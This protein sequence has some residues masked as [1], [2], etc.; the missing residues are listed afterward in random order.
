[1][2]KSVSIE[3]FIMLTI[4]LLLG[5][6]G[7]FGTFEVAVGP[8]VA[9][10][11]V[12]MLAGYAIF[13]PLLLVS[14]W[15]GE[16]LR[17]PQLVAGGL[18]LVIGAMPQTYLVAL[19]FVGFD[20]ARALKW[21][22]LPSLYIQVWVIGFLVNAVFVF[23]LGRRQEHAANANVEEALTGKESEV[24]AQERPAGL[25]TNLG[26]DLGRVNAL[27]GEDHYVR[28]FAAGGEHLILMRLRDAIAAVND[29]E[30]VQVHR[31]WWVARPAVASVRRVGRTAELTLIDGT[32]VPVARDMMPRLR[33]L[34]WL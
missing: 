31:S 11:S 18:A 2:I 21:D 5:F 25:L 22:G 29:N 26:L 17:I 19:Y 27:K 30:G 34:R 24:Y 13:R 6:I 3:I 4:G 32:V 15:V 8:R 10:W 33:E 12:T 9:Y 28:V 20:F 1:M 23:T 16:A 14:Q 7:P